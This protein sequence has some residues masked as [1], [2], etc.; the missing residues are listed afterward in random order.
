MHAHRQ[1]EPAKLI[2]LLKKQSPKVRKERLLHF[3]IPPP[4]NAKSLFQDSRDSIIICKK[5]QIPRYGLDL[6]IDHY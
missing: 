3:Y 4:I 6:F 2:K 5:D 1:E